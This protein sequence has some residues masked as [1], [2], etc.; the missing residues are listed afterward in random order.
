MEEGWCA[1]G[2]GGGS[3]AE[4]RDGGGG[5]DGGEG[6]WR[7]DMGLVLSELLSLRLCLPLPITTLQP[8][9]LLRI[10][11]YISY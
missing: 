7:S 1:R 6:R 8:A 11:L 2:G 10:Y 4:G 9:F 5:G 3:A